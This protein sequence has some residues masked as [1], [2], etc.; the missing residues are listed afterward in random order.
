MLRPYSF[1][2]AQNTPN[3]VEIPMDD[4]T[5]IKVANFILLDDILSS[6]NPISAY[7][8]KFD[9]HDVADVLDGTGKWRRRPVPHPE[10]F[11]EKEARYLSS[12]D[13]MCEFRCRCVRRHVMTARSKNL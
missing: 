3:I 2:S 11:W 10:R 4:S 8:E 6:S 7:L 12:P 5:K 1:V 9:E 13:F